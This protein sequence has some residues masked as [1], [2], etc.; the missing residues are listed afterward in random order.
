MSM[1]GVSLEE[2][3]RETG[4]KHTQLDS[5]GLWVYRHRIN[6]VFIPFSK[7]SKFLHESRDIRV[8]GIEFSLLIKRGGGYVLE[9]KNL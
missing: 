2:M 9:R 7:I 5:S 4:F 1:T 8:D 3:L 6:E